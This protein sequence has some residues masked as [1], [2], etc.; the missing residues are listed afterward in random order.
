MHTWRR[1]KADGTEWEVRIISEPGGEGA[2]REIIEFRALDGSSQPRR[3]AVPR[4]TLSD[5][6]DDDLAAVY[7]RAAPIAG[8]HYGRPGKPMNDAR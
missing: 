1:I 8:D 3:T 2:E 7:R 5:L 4:D 6:S